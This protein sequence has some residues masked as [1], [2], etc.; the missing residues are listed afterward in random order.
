VVIASARSLAALMHSIDAGLVAKYT[1]TAR[2][3][4]R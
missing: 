1:C 3:A 4:G 2:R